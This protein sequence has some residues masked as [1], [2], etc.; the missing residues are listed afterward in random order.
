MTSPTPWRKRRLVALAAAT[1][2]IT[3]LTYGAAVSA[4]AP[5]LA[6]SETRTYIVQ[7]GDQPLAAYDGGVRGLAATKPRE[8][9]KVDVS[10]A[11]SRAYLAHLET[12]RQSALRSLGLTQER[13][14][15]EY[16]VVFN[17]VAIELTPA[18][19]QHLRKDVNVLNV[20][21]NQPR[22][23]DTVQTPD[24]LRLR[25]EGGVW[26]TELGGAGSA[27]AGIVVGVLDTGIDPNNPSFSDEGMPAPPDDWT[28]ACDFG[29][30][31]YGSFEC[32][33][34]IVGARVYGEEF[35]NDTSFDFPSARDRNGHGSHTASTA[36]G[37]NGVEI[38]IDGNDMGVASGMAPRAHIAVYKVAWDDGAG[39]AFAWD[40]GSLAAVEDAVV[41]GVDVI[42]FSIGGSRDTVL[43]PVEFAF[44]IAADAGVFVAASAGNDGDLGPS[45]VE[46]NSPWTMT[47]AAS[48]ND[49]GAENVL[50][51]GNDASYTGVGYGG[52]VD[53]ELV[54]AES[55]PAAGATAAE[56]DLCGPGTVD[57]AGAAGKIVVCTRGEHALVDKAQE[58]ADSGGIAMVLVNAPGGATSLLA[59]FYPVPATH[60]TAED[61][62]EV[63]AYAAGTEAPTG[64]ISVTTNTVVNAPQ[65][66]DFSSTGPALAGEGD[67]LKPDI[68]APGV[69]VAAAYGVHPETGEPTFAQISGTSMSSPHIAGIAALVRQAHP[70]WSPAA[71]KSALMTTAR[72]TMDDGDPITRG[73]APATP[74]DYGAGEVQPAEA[75]DVGLVYDADIEDWT[76][77]VCAIGEITGCGETTDP[78]DLNYPSIAI[79][80][81]T[82]TQTVTR[83]VTSVSEVT[84]TYTVEVEQPPGVTVTVEPTS[85]TVAPG[86][87]ATYH[88]HFQVQDTATLDA[89]TF[90]ALT[91]VSDAHRVRSAIAVLPKALAAPDEVTGY[92]AYGTLGTEVVPGGPETFT[93]SVEGLVPSE[94]TVAQPVSDG[95]SGGPSFQDAVIAVPVPAG[96][97]V[98][99][100]SVFDAEVSV[101]GTDMDLYLFDPDGFFVDLSGTPGSDESITLH[102]PVA[103][104]YFLAIDYWDAPAGATADVPVHVWTVPST[105][106]GN[107]TVT[108]ATFTGAT[109]VPQPVTLDWA[110]LE[111]GTR[112][113]GAVRYNV[114]TEVVARTLVSILPGVDRWYG[115][116][117]YETAAAIA[118]RYDPAQVHTVC[119]ATGAQFPD[120]L[121]AAAGCPGSAPAPAVGLDG[122]PAPVLLTRPGALP[123]ATAQA[124]AVLQPAQVV[125]IGGPAAV[126]PAVEATLAQS[127]DVERVAGPDRYGTAAAIAT[128]FPADTPRVYVASGADFPDALAG[129]AL[130][131]HEGVPVLLTRP[132]GVPAATA[133]ALAHFT[134]PDLEVVVLGGPVAVSDAVFAALGA[135]RRIAGA[136]RY[137]TAVAISQAIGTGIDAPNVLVASGANFPDALA[138]SAYAGAEGIPVLLTRPD[139]VP[140]VTM[141]ELD[142]LSPQQTTLLGGPVAVTRAVEILLNG[143]FADWLVVG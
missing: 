108:P 107:L 29:T 46:H 79:G 5:Q 62:A 114:G 90:G 15:A 19:A 45:T 27:G 18:E 30:D 140:E 67:L 74:L 52:P 8:G 81:L 126:S 110:G 6:D 112:Y 100:V 63:K 65:M 10:S 83:T 132:D 104:T 73:G 35:G 36:A 80:S 26:E 127:Y 128:R 32:N 101:P 134:N 4:A 39:R 89:Y 139:G 57:D 48:T 75:F 23:L 50:T 64:S 53:G 59:I 14:V 120:A 125:I 25:G 55:I 86:A 82:G 43:D 102:D 141:A 37:N 49:R 136:D 124:L 58:V 72:Q 85:I 60:L 123:P 41:D 1:A 51:L 105:D 93:A 3:P 87:S 34:K 121:A 96:T 117:R 88:V 92:G 68:T 98:L 76:N 111:Y 13:V 16:E 21:E 31:E 66:A 38:T 56:A 77:Y 103:G 118:M 109:A 113:L 99:R 133:A 106:E 12:R 115:E 78:S 22:R 142:A 97:T 95:P 47:V 24:Y 42:N 129:S 119:I 28:G 61:G 54:N 91:W 2:L 135:E 137:E 33:N 84:E 143:R 70:D 69:D 9:E 20:W 40:A 17:G 94:V 131:G 116:D 122:S 71:I 7:F 11:R 130:A 44:L 138:G